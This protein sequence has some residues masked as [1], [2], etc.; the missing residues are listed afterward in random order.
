MNRVYPYSFAVRRVCLPGHCHRLRSTLLHLA[1]GALFGVT[2]ALASALVPA[3]AAVDSGAVLGLPFTRFYS[4]EEIGSV[5]R[6]ARL[7]FDSLGR[8]AV[9]YQGACVVLNDT[10]W[11]DIADKKEN[12]PRIQHAVFGPD[13][14][15]YF[16]ASG[17][18]GVLEF[19]AEGLLRPRSL[20]PAAYPKWILATNFTDIVPT[21]QGVYFSGF[22][23]VAYWDRASNEHVFFEVPQVSRIFTINDQVFIFSHRL[24]IQQLDLAT[25]SARPVPGIGPASPVIDQVTALDAGRVLVSTIAGRLMVFDGNTLTA[26]PGPLG[27]QAGARI[28]AL[29]RLVDGRIAVAISGKGLYLVSA[30]GEMVSLLTSPEY[31]RITDLATREAGVLWV[32][33]ENGVEKILY[34]SALTVF[35]QRLGLPI[36]WPQVVHWKDC[37][38]VA[39]GGRLYQA[40][41]CG[42]GETARFELIPDQPTAENWGIASRGERLLVGNSTGVFARTED[43]R[44]APVLTGMDVARLVMVSPEL[45]FAIGPSEITALRWA[46]ERWSEC[47]PRI[48]AVGY[49]AVVLAAKN[50]AW[51]E[52]GANRAARISLHEGRLQARI[53][54]Q[55]PWTPEWINLGLVGDIVILRA[56]SKGQLFFDETTESFVE[57]PQLERMIAHAPHSISRIR[58]DETGTI[59]AS[60]QQGLLMLRA[61]DDGQRNDPVAFIVNDRFPII[62]LLP[63]GDV[64][65]SSGQSL[66]HV[67]RRKRP[68]AEPALRPALVSIV[69]GRTNRELLTPRQ[70]APGPLAL[71]YAENNLMFRFFAGSYASRR[72]PVY[73]FKLNRGLDTWVPLGSGSLLSLNGLR[74]GSYHLAV[75]L[76]DDRADAAE[77]LTLDFKIA[78]PWFRTWYAYTFYALGGVSAIVGLICLSVYRTRSRNQ[79]LE[80]IVRERTDELRAAMQQLNEETRNAATVAE[81]DRLAGEIHDSLQQGLSGL[82]LQLDA[83]L[84]LPSLSP[85]VRSRLNVARNM[86]SFTRHEVQHAVW[87][88]ESPLLEESELGPALQKMAALISPETPLVEITVTGSS[89]ALSSS[90]RHHLLRIAQ[91]AITNAVRHAAARTIAV[92]LVCEPDTVSLSVTDDGNGFVPAEVLSHGL[93]HFGL[94]SLRGR[95]SKIGG[96]IQI[97]SAP[98]QGTSIKIVVAGAS[99]YSHATPA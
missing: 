38:V 31:H 47:A 25:H 15:A 14:R 72:A 21:A 82:I 93:G 85:D 55:F 89:A 91:E 80:T 94:R 90:T 7:G 84:K 50:S 24:G 79:V 71:S 4:L 5:S 22:N 3:S 28:S 54:E 98:G 16:G 33:T 76:A 60:F 12:R 34:E 42:V 73:E 35:G 59:W 75:R 51:V 32:A 36:S 30:D 95:A 23:G 52:L 65:L 6:G 99:A 45:C 67:D 57:A 8:L 11:I 78:P 87:D 64:W 19:T 96:E 86:V 1:R 26:W 81:R 2:L 48:P 46:D 97:H 18:W 62:H 63:G 17:S 29:Q 61:A 49:P 92:V 74:E 27:D 9:T 53:F 43:G 83:T 39:S 13:G 40:A 68:Q 70:A 69:D 37:V 41:P 58:Q 66:Y 88:L 56:L 20:L 44:F 10:T 77:M